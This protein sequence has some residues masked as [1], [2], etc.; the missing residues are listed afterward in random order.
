MLEEPWESRVIMSAEH[1]FSS[2]VE[3]VCTWASEFLWLKVSEQLGDWLLFGYWFDPFLA[4]WSRQS[5]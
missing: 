4:V 1:S 5:I 2:H 3:C